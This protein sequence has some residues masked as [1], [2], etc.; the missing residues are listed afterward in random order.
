MLL[1]IINN[2]DFYHADQLYKGYK[3]EIINMYV[4][5]VN[6]FLQANLNLLVNIKIC[7]ITIS[8]I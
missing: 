7:N 2:I 6:N 4:C 1:V 5:S 8:R 3:L